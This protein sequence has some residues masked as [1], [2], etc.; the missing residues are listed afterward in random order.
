MCDTCH[1]Q[2][3]FGIRWKCAECTNYDLCSVCYHCDK[4]NLRHRFFRINTP[5]SERLVWLM[6][7]RC[8]F[9]SVVLI[10]CYGL[11]RLLT[12]LHWVFQIP[13]LTVCHYYHAYTLPMTLSQLS[14]CFCLLLLF[15]SADGITDWFLLCSTMQIVLS[16]DVCLSVCPSVH[17][18]VRF[19]HA[20]IVSKPRNI[21]SHVF[22][23]R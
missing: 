18:S 7:Y 17:L 20:G 10:Q 14:L 1:Q 3:I 6:C 19:S 15:S 16:Q 2:P 12:L 8:L 22:T 11:H 5:G 13:Y 4:H 9:I 21:S 23:V